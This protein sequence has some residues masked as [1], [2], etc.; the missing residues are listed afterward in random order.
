MNCD[1]TTIPVVLTFFSC[2]LV[3]SIVEFVLRN[4]FMLQYNLGVMG[5]HFRRGHN[6][7]LFGP[8]CVH[9]LYFPRKSTEFHVMRKECQIILV[10]LLLIISYKSPAIADRFP[11][12]TFPLTVFN[13]SP[14][15]P[16]LLPDHSPI[17]PRSNPASVYP[18][19]FY[20]IDWMEIHTGLPLYLL[21]NLCC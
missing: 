19:L 15:T 21:L 7:R 6:Q 8:S 20:T 1:T 4:L 16:R 18:P 9:I 13:C 17:T 14:I 5:H 2:L 11:L 3:T 12:P 10:R